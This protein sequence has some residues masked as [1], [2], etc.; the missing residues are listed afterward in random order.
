[1]PP[2]INS[3]PEIQ[4]DWLVE[5]KSISAS[6]TGGQLIRQAACLAGGGEHEARSNAPSFA[7]HGPKI[8]AG[9]P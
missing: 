1:V 3:A 9:G 6:V 8:P 5:T 4:S 2:P 7:G